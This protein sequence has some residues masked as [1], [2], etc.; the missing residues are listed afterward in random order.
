MNI[1]TGYREQFK[2]ETISTESKSLKI[3]LVREL[4]GEFGLKR[5][6]AE[7]LFLRSLTWLQDMINDTLPGQVLISVPAANCKS[8]THKKRLKARLTFVD[9]N[10]DGEIWREYGLDVMQRRRAVRIIYEIW[11]QGGWGS[12]PGIAAL[13][14]LTPNALSDLLVPLMEVG[15]WIP[16]V[17]EKTPLNNKFFWDSV[18]IKKF[19]EDE[20]TE[21][22]RKIFGLT[23]CELELAL[24]R[25]VSVWVLKREIGDTA[26]IGKLVG[27]KVEEVESIKGIVEGYGKRKSWKNLESF[28][29]TKGNYEEVE[30]ERL[31]WPDIVEKEHGMS[32]MAAR[33]YV[34][35]LYELADRL[36]REI[37]KG[38]GEMIFF[39]E[40]SDEKAGAGL[41]ECKVVSIRLKYFTDEELQP[42]PGDPRENRLGDL[43]FA[44]ILRYTTEVRKQGGLLNIPDLAMLM[45]IG[46]D[47]VKE[48][49][50]AN[51]KITVP[52]REMVKN[53]GPDI[54]RK[55]EI[56][57]LYL[58][59]HTETE[60]LDRT[61]HSYEIIETYLR[62]FGQVVTLADR[63]LNPGM[64]CKETGISMPL[65]KTYLDLYKK[66]DN[67]P[68]YTFRIELLRR[69]F[70]RYETG[71]K[72]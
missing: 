5:L 71:T 69:G 31:D 46:V 21:E 72:D 16:H 28:Y 45:G 59:M 67:H 36:N 14:N 33:I 17:G 53:I 41:E 56:V 15:V 6:E 30:K 9:I 68:L 48:L 32:K 49:I 12:Y 18:L 70:A 19:L 10:R 27:L 44:R 34:R 7:V 51:P 55:G 39:A 54:S 58:R 1:S 22:I 25:A 29:T 50:E 64:I 42:G 40:S 37:P 43:K 20:S 3:L 61:G 2:F 60:I 47:A 65:V 66:Y 24:R 38:E 57:E 62:E 8:H 13:L 11:R 52:T 35:R 26:K 23:L 4:Q 63:G